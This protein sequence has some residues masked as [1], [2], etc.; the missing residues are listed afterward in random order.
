MLKFLKISFGFVALLLIA[1]LAAPFFINVN[2]YKPEIKEA[3]F[4]ATGRNLDIGN[5]KLSLFPWVGITLS[6]VTLENA[7]GFA[8]KNI[9]EVTTIDVQVALMP[10]IDQHIEVK[11]FE[12]NTP[13]IWLTQ[14]DDGSNNWSDLSKSKE[15]STTTPQT[16][17]TSANKDA[18]KSNNTLPIAFEAK[19]IQLVNGQVMW[20][21]KAKGEVVID[22]IQL[23]ITDLQLK[24]PIGIDFSANIGANPIQITAEVGPILDLN[25]FNPETLPV[26]A[27]IQSKQ[28]NLKPFLA[29]LPQLE[30]E[31]EA[32]FGKL[33][34]TNI[35]LDISLEQHTDKMLLSSGAVEVKGKHKL[36][37][38]W[39]LNVKALKTLKIDTFTLAMDD[40]DVLSMS[41]KV[42]NLLKKPRF[43]AKVTT[44]TLQRI[45]LNQFAPA[46][47][48]VYKEH[49]KPWE[50][51]KAEA[52]L[53]GDADI[54]EIRNLQLTLNDEP[55]QMSGDVALG[56]APDIQLRITAGDL[57]L[58]PW[59]PQSKKG[60]KS[61]AAST[62][63]SSTKGETE[64]D[65]TFLRPWYLSVQLQAKTIHAMK[66]KLENLRMTLSSEKGVVRLN[67]LSFDT[68][69]GHINENMT[70]YANQYPATWKQSLRM[71]GVSIQPILKALA[72]FD[73]LSGI[74]TLNAN[75]SGKGL[76]PDSIIHSA[77]GR[78]DFLFEDGQFKG[79]DIAKEVRKLKKQST[80][81]QKSDFAKMQGTFSV[82]NAVLT[83]N[84]LYM[85]SPLFRLSGKGKVYFDPAKLDYHVRPKLVQTLA[86]QGGSNSKKG[87]V[88]PLHIHGSFENIQVDV[89]MDKDALLN[90]AG[91]LNDAAGKPI[92]GVGGKVLD[93]GF[94]K[95][96]DEQTAKAKA[97]AKRKADAKIAA[98][99]ARL[100]A[101][102]KEKAKQKLKDAF[103]GFSF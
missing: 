49:P 87:L 68:N 70:L 2:D 60:N 42:R 91:A 64:P 85:A 84:D 83:N 63:N 77:T 7:Q 97:E 62:S 90:S 89:K 98:E 71:K 96:R 102:A 43:E 47:Q 15:A 52:F 57:H 11:R 79:V 1:L 92:G 50:T 41:G 61:A 18:P 51:I 45:W 13:K 73:K 99:K 22:D 94:V 86:G 4:D 19:L 75:L 58:D 74:T 88:V 82:R 59:I 31:Q 46:L 5:I 76:L 93:Q 78:G 36:H 44:G 34:D 3:V 25:T 30:A 23:D 20:S 24:Q 95:T 54:I 72:D 69:G 10:L 39:K 12:L 81:T 38:A 48:E 17:P 8:H 26:L 37:A 67:P 103:K 29:W 55:I 28:F 9:L 21:D 80:T 6:D 33:Q 27:R 32:Q 53:A 40:T 16:K 65:L 66:L 56:D 100:E 101:A 35:T 14:H